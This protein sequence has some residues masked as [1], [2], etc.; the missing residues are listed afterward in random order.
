MGSGIEQVTLSEARGNI[1]P[2]PPIDNAALVMGTASSAA[3]GMHGP[4][5]NVASLNADVGYGPGPTAAAY[6]IAEYGIPVMLYV[7]PSSVAG[8]AAATTTSAITGSASGS[9]A[10]GGAPY[11]EYSVWWQSQ[12]TA[13][14]GTAMTLRWALDYNSDGNFTQSANVN[15][16]TALTYAIPNSGVVITLGASGQ[17]YANGDYGTCITT[18]PKWADADIDTA[19]LP[20]GAIAQSPYNFAHLYLAGPCSATDAGHVTTLLN[21]LK[22]AGKIVEAVVHTAWPKVDGTQSETAWA[23]SVAADFLSFNDDRIWPVEGHKTRVIDPYTAQIWNRT[24]AYAFFARMVASERNVWPASPND[25]GFTDPNSGSALVQ[26][27]DSN[28]VLLGHDEGPSGNITGLS[29]P[30][31]LGNRFVCIMRGQTVNTRRTVYTT[32]PWVAYT[33]GGTG[34][35]FTGM[36]RRIAHAIE[37]AALEVSFPELGGTAFYVTDSNGVSTL[38]PGAQDAIHHVIFDALTGDTFADDIQNSADDNPTTGLVQVQSVITV[39]P[40]NLELVNVI[41]APKVAGKIL[42]INLIYA[43]T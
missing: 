35:I 11:N 4:Y 29:D 40:G 33:V 2:T 28:N 18:G 1:A 41:L 15:V 6:L 21:N 22:T 31:G 38:T 30:V 12:G 25:G 8:T 37:R 17:T 43:A 39:A 42:T 19:G 23:A 27:Y 9:A 20:N 34:R 10:V 13:A 16:G 26:L 7:T 36:Q 32:V 14:V 24:W 5:S 3:T